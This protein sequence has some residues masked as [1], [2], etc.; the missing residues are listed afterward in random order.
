MWNRKN[1]LEAGWSVRRIRDDGSE[2]QYQGTVMQPRLLDRFDGTATRL[3]GYAQQSWMAWNG[4]AHV[5]GGARWDR[6]SLDGV[7]AV[8]PQTSANVA[9]TKSMH[10]QLGWGQYAQFPEV[11]L[12]TSPLGGRWLPPMRSNHAIAAVE[13]RLGARTRV[14]AEYYN[15]AD[16]DLPFQPQF[17]PRYRDGKIFAPPLNPPYFASLRG[18]SR[19]V[20]FFLQRSSANRFTGFPTASAAPGCARA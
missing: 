8:T 6:E 19:G 12:L 16:R 2:I 9:V 4:R 10:V 1:P 11:S 7:S 13:Q 18:Y 3:G 20:E 14:R 15:R 5:T 17:D